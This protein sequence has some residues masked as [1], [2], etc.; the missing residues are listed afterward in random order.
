MNYFHITLVTSPLDYDY[1]TIKKT[2]T[3]CFVKPFE[4]FPNAICT[5]VPNIDLSFRFLS[6]IEANYFPF[7]FFKETIFLECGCFETKFVIFQNDQVDLNNLPLE[8]FSD[9]NASFV[10]TT[11]KCFSITTVKDLENFKNFIDRNIK[12]LCGY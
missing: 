5:H 4:R 12:Y 9:L 7:K 3:L 10:D 1:N 2:D 8:Q 11:L 6:K